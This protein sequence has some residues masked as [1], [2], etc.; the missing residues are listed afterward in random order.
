MISL[1]DLCLLVLDYIKAEGF[2][3]CILKATP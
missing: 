1:L 2:D 3:A